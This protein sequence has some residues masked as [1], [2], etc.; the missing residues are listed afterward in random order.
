MLQPTILE[1]WKRAGRIDPTLSLSRRHLSALSRRQLR[2]V[3]FSRE[4]LFSCMAK[5]APVLFKNLPVPVRGEHKLGV[6]E[7][8]LR[9][10]NA[11]FPRDFN[12]RVRCGPGATPRRMVIEEMLRRWLSG[13]ARI[14]V[15]DLH[16]RGTRVMSGIQSSSLSEFNI[17]AEDKGAVGT[18]EMLTM[19]VSSAGTFTDSHTDDPDG[20]NHCFVGR[21]LWLVWDTC[22]GLSHKLEDVERCQLY[23]RDAAFSMAGFLSVPGS[24]WFIVEPG[25][26]LF[27]PGQLTHKVITL[28]DYLGVGSF[29]VMLPGY[30]RTLAR[31]TEHTPLWALNLPAHRRME[32]VDQ[33]TKRVID[34]VYE[35]TSASEQQRSRW[36]IAHLR[37]AVNDWQRTSSAQ[38]Q[39]SLL[40]NPLSAK[41]MRSVLG[42]NL[43]PTAN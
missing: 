10:L 11:G 2:P 36:G 15:T 12:V 9:A 30:L 14:S 23:T 6:R 1:V 25:Y 8:V 43:N 21:K 32:L 35:L 37:A 19:V 22:L 39:D 33:I 4:L 31:W 5:G 26:T 41:L 29:F 13:R 40:G 16:I 24:R 18:E 28:E 42:T 20:S 27:L 7:A 38:A 3:S 34:K 17:L